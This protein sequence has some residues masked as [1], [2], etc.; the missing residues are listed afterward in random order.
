MKSRL[1]IKLTEIGGDNMDPLK[2]SI[3]DLKELATLA[4]KTKNPVQMRYVFDISMVL[5]E[6]LE[7]QHDLCPL[8]FNKIVGFD[9]EYKTKMNEAWILWIKENNFTRC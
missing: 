5:K 6:V 7:I 4:M 9:N 2:I 1:V 3:I 8:S